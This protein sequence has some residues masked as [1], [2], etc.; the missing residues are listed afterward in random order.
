MANYK[1]LFMSYMDSSNVKYSE[2]REDVVKVVFKGDNLKSIPIFV[3]F[4]KDGKPLVSLICG[5]ITNFKGNKVTT[6]IL[7]CNDMNNKYS[8]VKFYVNDDGN[9]HAKIDVDIDNNTCGRVCLSLIVR[10]AKI[11]DEAYPVFMKAQWT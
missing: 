2:P 7:S 5:E 11:I 1:S 4:D 9:V 3:F 10:M 6:G 8:W